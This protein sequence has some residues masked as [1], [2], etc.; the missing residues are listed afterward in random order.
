MVELRIQIHVG[1][2]L[3]GMM[4][5]DIHVDRKLLGTMLVGS[6]KF[7]KRVGHQAATKLMKEQPC[8]VAEPPS[9]TK[10]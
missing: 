3:L 2:K 5:V 8:K 6:H 10:N 4:L 7:G 1:Q 9:E